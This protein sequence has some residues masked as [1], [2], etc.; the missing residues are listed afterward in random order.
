M[1]L[2]LTT[3]MADPHAS[4]RPPELTL[5]AEDCPP[6]LSKKPYGQDVRQAAVLIALSGEADNALVQQMRAAG[7]WPSERTVWR[8]RG[9]LQQTGSVAPYRHT[10]NKRS[11]VLRGEDLLLLAFFSCRLSEVD[12]C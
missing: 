5:V 1:R 12:T 6:S 7:R 10:G 2:R 4:V 11:D 3:P 9:R 8:W